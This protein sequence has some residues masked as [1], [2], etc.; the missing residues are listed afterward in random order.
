VT[1]D[2]T[3]TATDG[4]LEIPAVG[5]NGGDPLPNFLE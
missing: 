3:G 4:L 5:A 2:G 1:D